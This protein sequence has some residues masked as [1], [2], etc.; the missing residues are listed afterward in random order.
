MCAGVW[1]ALSTLEVPPGGFYGRQPRSRR[2]QLRGRLRGVDLEDGNRR[3]KPI[4]AARERLNELGVLYAIPER[5]P[6]LADGGIE[7]D[8][9]VDESVRRPK[10]PLQLLACHEIS[11]LLQ[12][13]Q[14]DASRLF[15]QPDA[16]AILAQLS[17]SGLQFEPAEPVN[18]FRGY[19]AYCLGLCKDHSFTRMD[20]LARFSQGRSNTNVLSVGQQV[21]AG[22]LSLYSTF[23]SLTVWCS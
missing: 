4:A 6:E 17:R 20:M 15:L 23:A 5:P 14:E 9:K 3:G 16:M 13:Q 12:K 11:R 21:R 2:K 8:I 10:H 22:G 19:G 1:P 18:A 7:T